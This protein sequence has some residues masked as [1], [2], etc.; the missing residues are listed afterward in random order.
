MKK[1]VILMLTLF[2]TIGAHDSCCK[3]KLKSA[4]PEFIPDP[5]DVEPASANAK[6]IPDP[7]SVDAPSGWDEE[8]DG[9]WEVPLIPNPEYREWKPRMIPNPEF[10][11][12]TLLDKIGDEVLD[13][14]PWVVLGV[15]LT[16]VLNIVT[17][18]PDP[19]PYL[20][21]LP[22]TLTPNPHPKRKP[23]TQTEIPNPNPNFADDEQHFY[24]KHSRHARFG[25]L[26]APQQRIHR[27]N[28]QY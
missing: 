17:P 27:S 15:L 26:S 6:M 13:T 23:Q 7:E 1:C 5:E 25:T 11:R 3:D 2:V 4:A 21:P 10:R 22:Q 14:A 19:N 28:R 18:N 8:D 16:A 12:H 9:L 20:K 24:S